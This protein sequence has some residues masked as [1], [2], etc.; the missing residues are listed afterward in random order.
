MSR[1]GDLHHM[2]G[3]VLD[4][5]P[6]P[7]VAEGSAYPVEEIAWATSERLLA[8]CDEELNTM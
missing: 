8:R 6:I 7:Q 2:S 1:M 3:R 5:E 4:G